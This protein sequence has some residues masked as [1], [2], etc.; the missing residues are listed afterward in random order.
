M[1]AGNRVLIGQIAGAHGIKGQV[2]VRSYTA[3][4]ADIA[5]YGPL[6][7]ETGQYTYEL[8]VQRVSPKGVYAHIKN[9][10]DRNAAEALR[11]IQLYVD[12]DAMP[13]SEDG[14]FYVTDL[15]GLTAVDE[16]SDPLGDIKAVHNF[17]AG[18]ILEVTLSATGKT[19]LVPFTLE[20]VPD[21]DIS[22][23]RAT[24]ILPK[25]NEDDADSDAPMNDH[26][27]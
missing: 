3:D 13:P 17:G 24:I 19:E 10:T 15:I 2:I 18:D 26:E 22:A 12:R 27:S 25:N 8:I 6:S 9:I 7:D 4:P 20:C 16:N 11:G 1:S 14:E 5:A 23:N 21:I